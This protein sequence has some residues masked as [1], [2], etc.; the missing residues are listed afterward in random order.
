MTLFSEYVVSIA[1]PQIYL[2]LNSATG[3]QDASGHGNSQTV[4]GGLTIGGFAST[5]IL[6]DEKST[7]FDGLLGYIESTTFAPFSGLQP[8]KWYWGGWIN[9]DTIGTIDTLFGTGE[10][11]WIKLEAE[12]NQRELYFSPNWG[13]AGGTFAKYPTAMP[14]GGGVGVWTFVGLNVFRNPSTTQ[15]TTEAFINGVSIGVKGPSAT[16]Y[17]QGSGRFYVANW[18]SSAENEK[19]DGKICH[20]FS[21]YDNLSSFSWAQLYAAAEGKKL[22]AGKNLTLTGVG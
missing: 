5:P 14:V 16:S 6:G 4:Q 12:P 20:V 7:D 10:N 21:G 3:A 11:E 9:R 15:M 13:G 22:G 17:R 1:A 8:E 19:F 2:P 18:G